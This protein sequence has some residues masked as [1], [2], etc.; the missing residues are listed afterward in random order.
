[1]NT[2]NNIHSTHETHTH[3]HQHTSANKPDKTVCVYVCVRVCVYM[4]IGVCASPLLS[5][6]QTTTFLTRT[7]PTDVKRWISIQHD[8]NQ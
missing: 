6:E 1:M 4:S 5:A 8:V 7:T 3:T 2:N